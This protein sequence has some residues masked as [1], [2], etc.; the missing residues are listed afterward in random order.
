MPTTRA[1]RKPRSPD[2]SLVRTRDQKNNAR[3]KKN[4]D[5]HRGAR[6]L[7]PLLPG[8][9][10]WLPQRECEGE[11]QEEV[12]PQSYTVEFEGSSV[13]RT[14]RDLI[15]LPN[16]ESPEPNEQ[17]GSNSNEPTESS[18]NRET[19]PSELNKS[20][21]PPKVRRSSRTSRPPERLDPSW[22]N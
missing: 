22:L 4:F 8:D 19:Q 15:Q 17:N 10:V 20:S 6:E 9:L 18:A 7:L 5:S 14:R 12:A 2:L 13:R 21:A 11:V 3:Q 1:Q 16:S